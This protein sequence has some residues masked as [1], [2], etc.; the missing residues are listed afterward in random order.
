MSLELLQPID[1][2][3]LHSLALH[4]PQVLGKNIRIHSV[5]QGFPELNDARIALIGVNEIRQAYFDTTH[6]DLAGFRNAF[7]QLYPGNWSLNVCDLGDLP[8]GATVE[9]TYHAL[10]DICLSLRQRNI[11]P[12]IIGGSHDMIYPIYRSYATSNQL[13]NIVS[14]DNRFDFSQEEELI[15]GRSYMSK[16]IMEQPNYLQNY[17]NIGYQSYLIAQ[18]ELDLMEKLFFERIRLGAFIDDLTEVEP[19]LRDADIVGI[20]MKVMQAQ[21]TGMMQ[22][23]EPNGI[24]GRALCALA[25]YSGLSD[26]LTT[27]GVFE[28]PNTA[29]FHKLLAQTIWYFIEGVAHRFDEYPVL[30]SQGFKRYTVTMSEFEMVFYESE[31]S[32]RWWINVTNE[33][34]LDNKNARSTLL[35][36]THNDYK[37]ACNNILPERWWNAMKRI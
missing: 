17:T 19:P 18:E 33:N 31:K 3:L 29:L 7:Y 24:D 21:A 23:G 14:A 35:S 16:I 28:L 30:T 13:I 4:P 10:N 1:D 25:R 32:K 12:V 8:N 2:A 5:K 36:C 37:M 15:S 20:D 22:N 6:Y 27:F 34:Y 9:D 26:R 11:I